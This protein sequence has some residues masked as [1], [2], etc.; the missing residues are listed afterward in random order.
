MVSRQIR[1]CFRAP[2]ACVLV[3]AL[4]AGCAPTPAAAPTAAPTAAPAAK[5]TTAAAASPAT[6]PG[7]SPA[8]SPTTA[9]PAA[10]AK[11][12]AGAIKIGAVYDLSGSL[13]ALGV[14][15]AKGAQLYF[16]KLNAAGGINGQKVELTV[17]NGESTTDAAIAAMREL[18][19]QAPV[20]ILGP[21]SAAT[22]NAVRPIVDAA[23]IPTLSHQGGLD[24]GA[25]YMFTNTLAG[26]RTARNFALYMK[27]QNIKKA[28]WLVSTD[29]NGQAQSQL[30]GPLY[31]E[32]GVEVAAQQTIDPASSDYTTQLAA[33]KSAGAEAV[34]VFASGAPLVAAAKGFKALNM[35]GFILLLNTSDAQIPLFG[36]AGSVIRVPQP[37]VAVFDQIAKDDPLYGP[38]NE[39]IT[40]ARAASVPTD[41]F[42]AE[43]YDGARII[44]DSIK[45]VGPDS[46]KVFD[47]WNNNYKDDKHLAG[48]VLWTKDD[49]GCCGLNAWVAV[50]VDPAAAKFKVLGPWGD[51][52]AQ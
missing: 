48:T 39:F 8:A 52:K 29:A 51:P 35:P 25:G 43:G 42:G 3:L 40:A 1:K 14:P 2:L 33:L 47:L 31:K 34:M 17:L 12:A 30:A 26:T 6:S 19:K 45:Q 21:P 23:K 15:E 27:A 7:A 13:S 16:D 28:G 24:L 11:P 18:A 4:L 10:A 49:H 44:A 20:A 41:L 22:A 32:A 9:A 36:D 46:A 5:P 37:K 38:M 50:T